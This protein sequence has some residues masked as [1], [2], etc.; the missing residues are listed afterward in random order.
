MAIISKTYTYIYKDKTL[1]LNDDDENL[2]EKYNEFMKNIPE[3]ERKNA[4]RVVT[5]SY[6]QQYRKPNGWGSRA[7]K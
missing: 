3:N 5:I 4:Q 7:W 1:I 2:F 6:V